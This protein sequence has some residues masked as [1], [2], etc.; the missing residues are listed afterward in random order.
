MFSDELC[1]LKE[2]CS[3]FKAIKSG[4]SINELQKESE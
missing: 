2:L 4:Y 1:N 3:R